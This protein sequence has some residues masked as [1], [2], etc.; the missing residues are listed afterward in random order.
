MW[1][2]NCNILASALKVG[3]EILLISMTLLF[4]FVSWAASPKSEYHSLKTFKLQATYYSLR[5]GVQLG[6]ARLGPFYLGLGRVF[7]CENCDNN[8]N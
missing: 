5:V 4:D 2:E 3:S 7:T 8:A 6:L 1:S